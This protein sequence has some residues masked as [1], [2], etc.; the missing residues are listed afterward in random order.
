MLSQHNLLRTTAQCRTHRTL[1]TRTLPDKKHAPNCTFH[2]YMTHSVGI[3]YRIPTY[4]Q[5]CTS[6][7]THVFGPQIPG[8][9]RRIS[10][11]SPTQHTHPISTLLQ[12]IPLKIKYCN[13]SSHGHRCA[14]ATVTNHSNELTLSNNGSD[15]TRYHYL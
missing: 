5:T 12:D 10:A 3:P 6:L 14:T 15:E 1:R 7:K 9:L 4:H 11:T 8:L 2:L 13:V